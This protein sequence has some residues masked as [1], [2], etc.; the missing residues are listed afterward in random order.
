MNPSHVVVQVAECLG[1]KKGEQAVDL[2]GLSSLEARA[3]VLCVLSF[4]QQRAA[5][6]EP[7]EP[8]L[9]FITG[10]LPGPDTNSA[11]NAAR[12]VKHGSSSFRPQPYAAVLSAMMQGPLTCLML[13]VSWSRSGICLQVGVVEWCTTAIR[14]DDLFEYAS[15]CTQVLGAT[16]IP[17]RVLCCMTRCA[18]C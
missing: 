9:T 13:Q 11:Q 2:H 12:A 5:L 7:L 14:C 8:H 6:E 3:A 4:V 18:S 15:M 17:Y 16:A 10:A 1:L